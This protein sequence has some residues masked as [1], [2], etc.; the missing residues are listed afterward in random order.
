MV[1]GRPTVAHVAER[2]GVSVASVSRVLSDLPASDETRRKV[3]LAAAELRYRPNAAA[4]SLKMRRSHQLAFAVADVGNPVYVEMMRAV[5]DQARTAGYRLLIS[6]TGGR[7]SDVLELLDS[8][9]HGFTDGLILS[10]LR[11]E[12]ALLTA[13]RARTCPVV[14]IGT[15]PPETGV[16]SV[17]A[18]SADGVRMVLEHLFA[19][20]HRSVGFVNG[21]ADTV[22]G[23]SRRKAFE[24][25]ARA[26]G[27]DDDPDLRVEAGDFTFAE[28]RKAAARLLDRRVPDA[29]LGGNDLLAVAAMQLLA[30]RNMQIPEDVAVAGIDDT[31]LAAMTTPAL[32][33]VSLGARERGHRA[34]QLMLEALEGPDGARDRPPRC[35]TVQP[36]LTVRR[37]ST[38]RGEQPWPV[39]LTGKPIVESP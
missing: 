32:T 6:S 19:Q 36:L 23:S 38:A 17:R 22:P 4:R 30:E 35:V 7:T 14:V 8:L 28:G 5:E 24:L 20:G 21:P 12:P 33:S 1:A 27:L 26:L 16:D 13:L 11:V 37:S 9:E 15:V 2:A 31:D 39:P 25:T 29:L 3:Q 18:N 34:A 10:P